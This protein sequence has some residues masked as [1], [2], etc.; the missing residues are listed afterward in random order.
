[1]RLSRTFPVCAPQCSC[2]RHRR[3]WAAVV[4]YKQTLAADC[5]SFREPLLRSWDVGFA[6]STVLS[7]VNEW[8]WNRAGHTYHCTV[9]T[10]GRTRTLWMPDS[11]LQVGR[12]WWTA[13]FYFERHT[14]HAPCAQRFM[15]VCMTKLLSCWMTLLTSYPV[16]YSV[17]LRS[18]HDCF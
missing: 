10:L 5:A 14:V 12:E 15:A 8:Q 3:V 4:R 7:V 6:S 18:Q 17:G 1:M 2:L 16:I 11:K 13:R 9:W